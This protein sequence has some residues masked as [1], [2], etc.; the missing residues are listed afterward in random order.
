MVITLAIILILLMMNERYV[1]FIHIQETPY[2]ATLRFV[3]VMHAYKKIDI[4][5]I[6]SQGR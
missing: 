1:Y 4:I 6:T 2:N 3:F 5:E